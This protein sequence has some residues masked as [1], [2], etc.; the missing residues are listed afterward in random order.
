M[1]VACSR[2]SQMVSEKT[3]ALV[4]L[5]RMGRIGS[6]LNRKA[7]TIR[8]LV[9]DNIRTVCLNVG[10]KR[11]DMEHPDVVNIYSF[12]RC[13]K[14]LGKPYQSSQNST[15][16]ITRMRNRGTRFRSFLPRCLSLR[17]YVRR[18]PQ[19]CTLD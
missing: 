11:A 1:Q 5:G 15:R 3:L 8:G 7:F 13:E 16:M 12:A 4:Y 17:R 19:A 14:R 2:L 6:E 9:L 18:F 10:L